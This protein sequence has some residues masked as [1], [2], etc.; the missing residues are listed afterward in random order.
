M[1]I[2]KKLSTDYDVTVLNANLAIT[3]RRVTINGNLDVIGSTTQVGTIDTFI[4]DNFITLAAGQ[5]GGPTLTAGIEVERGT[6]PKVGIRWNEAAGTWEYTN[7]GTV[8]RAFSGTKLIEDIN[9]NLGGNLIVNN[10]TI[11]SNPGD[12]VVIVAGPGGDLVL[13][14]VIRLPYINF[15]P[16]PKAGHSTIYAKPTSAGST[17]FYVSN[18]R[19][20]GEELI[21]KRKAFVYSLIL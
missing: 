9:P 14:P 17:G 8:W 13:G 10:F 7:D 12:D 21:T 19:A 1:A 6:D 4:Y 11:T 15:D 5:P 2:V 20:V 18:D 3:A 16:E